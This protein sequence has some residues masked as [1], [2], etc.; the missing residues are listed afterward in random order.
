MIGGHFLPAVQRELKILAIREGKTLGQLLSEALSDLLVKRGLPSVEK[1]E[2]VLSSASGS[3]G[4]PA[5]CPH[6]CNPVTEHAYEC[7][8]WLPEATT[9]APGP[10]TRPPVNAATSPR[11]IAPVATRNPAK[12]RAATVTDARE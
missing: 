2:A 10:A 5:I 11:T 8:A 9:G 1:L 4:L 3:P 12:R 6:C 7:I